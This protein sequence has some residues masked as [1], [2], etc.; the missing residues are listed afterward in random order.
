MDRPTP[1]TPLAHPPRLLD[2]VRHAIRV[3]H[4]SYR[5][6]QAYVAWIRR[7]ILFQRKRHP[8]EMGREEIEAFLS[9]L[10][11]E[12][13]VAASTQN[14]ALAALLFLYRDVLGVQVGWL[15][16]LV[17]AKRPQRLPVV[18]TAEEVARVLARLSGIPW[19]MAMVLYGSGVRLMECHRL[20]VK[21]LDFDRGEI[22]VRDGKGGKDRVTTLPA[23]VREPLSEHL[24]RVRVQHGRDLAGGL[25]RVLL[26]HAIAVKY[27]NADCEWGWQWIF[28]AARISVDPRTGIRRRHHLDPSVLQRALRVAARLA[29]IA[30]PV[31]PHTLRHCFAT[32]LLDAGYDI[33]TVQEL[34]GHRDVATTMIYTHVLNRG[35][36]AVRSPAD[37]LAA[38]P[39]A[40]V[41]HGPPNSPAGVRN[42]PKHPMPKP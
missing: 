14:Q 15:A 40:A 18:L 19:L 42:L 7:F 28:P 1:S 11:V 22:V 32:H 35:G 5:T 13:R 31:G 33:R 2:E 27:P 17:R 34:L 9:A 20:R 24:A 39:P 37:L 23:C 16:E 8:R 12:R 21:D 4:Y 41:L 38:P 10:A 30:K 25:G 3:R 29:G 26:P 6:E 36:R